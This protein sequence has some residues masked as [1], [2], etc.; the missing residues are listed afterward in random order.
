MNDIAQTLS[1]LD[2]SGLSI[3]ATIA[4]AYGPIALAIV[5]RTMNGSLI[6]KAH[7]SDE[8]RDVELARVGCGC[9][10]GSDRGLTEG[11]IEVAI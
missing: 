8:G 6:R 3:R 7:A 1:I 5:S 11:F 10:C 4:L 2:T 9:D